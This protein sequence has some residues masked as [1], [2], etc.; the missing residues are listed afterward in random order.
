MKDG[1]EERD[2]MDA[3]TLNLGMR[4]CVHAEK[5]RGGNWRV[6]ERWRLAL[7]HAYTLAVIRLLAKSSWRFAVFLCFMCVL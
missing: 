4:D 6:R 1:G 5:E 7:E 3:N 2:D